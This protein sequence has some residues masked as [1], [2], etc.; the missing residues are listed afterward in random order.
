MMDDPAAVVE[1]AAF[2]ELLYKRRFDLTKPPPKPVPRYLL[3]GKVIA[4]PANLCAIQAPVKAGQVRVRR[5]DDSEHNGTNRGLS[6]FEVIK[7]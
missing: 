5:C 6:R 7:S 2:A 3:L 1:A 4:T